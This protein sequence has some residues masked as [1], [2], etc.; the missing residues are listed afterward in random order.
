MPLV[1][2]FYIYIYIYVNIDT[3]IYIY[4]PPNYK[5]NTH[6]DR[7]FEMTHL[8]TGYRDRSKTVIVGLWFLSQPLPHKTKEDSVSCFA[9]G[10]VDNDGPKYQRFH[11]AD[12]I[13]TNTSGI[14][15]ARAAL[16]DGDNNNNPANN[17]PPPANP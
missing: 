13:G 14:A 12:Q 4:I 8:K 16:T 7:P 3:S 6:T 2:Y 5:R 10:V 17:P 9:D 15:R 1:I 11:P